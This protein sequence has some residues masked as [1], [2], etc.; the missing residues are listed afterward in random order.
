[1]V[2]TVWI[3]QLD[4]A[5]ADL[6]VDARAVFLDGRRGLHRTTNGYFLLMLFQLSFGAI[7]VRLG[8]SERLVE[9]VQK[10]TQFRND[11]R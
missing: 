11:S 7:Q 8:N 9:T 6:L 4:L 3:D 5:D 1:M 10:S 2:V